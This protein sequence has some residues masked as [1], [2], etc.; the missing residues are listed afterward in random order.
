MSNRDVTIATVKDGMY[1]TASEQQVLEVGQWEMALWEEEGGTV[2]STVFCWE[3]VDSGTYVNVILVH[4][5]NLNTAADSLHPVM[6]AVCS[7]FNRL[8][9]P[10]TIQS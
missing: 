5:T 9:L 6:A 7:F 4:I 1:E 10:A 3:T 8:M 2:L